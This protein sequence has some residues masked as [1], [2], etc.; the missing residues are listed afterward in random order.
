MTYSNTPA[1]SANVSP[2]FIRK[3]LIA[4]VLLKEQIALRLPIN[5]LPVTLCSGGSAGS[6][7]ETIEV[8]ALGNNIKSV[9]R[10]Y[11]KLPLETQYRLFTE[12]TLPAVANASETDALADYPRGVDLPKVLF[13]ASPDPTKPNGGLR[14]PAGCEIAVAL[15]IAVAEGVVVTVFG[16]DY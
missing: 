2:I 5:Q 10:L 6:F 15:G 1:P 9:L 11:Y 3:P 16:G 7:I 13:P 14:L 8:M 4:S 12:H